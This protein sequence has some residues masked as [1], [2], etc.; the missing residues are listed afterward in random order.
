MMVKG[1]YS[2][3][4]LVV[5]VPLHLLKRAW[6]GPGFFFCFLGLGSCRRVTYRCVSGGVPLQ[7]GNSL[8]LS[9]QM[10]HHP[11]VSPGGHGAAGN[12]MEILQQT[13]DMTRTAS[14]CASVSWS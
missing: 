8:M 4:V 12:L 3:A 5:V 11:H 13:M 6:L 14:G 2:C 1:G 10:A 9:A 7:H